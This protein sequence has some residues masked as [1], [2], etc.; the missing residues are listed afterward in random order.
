[1]LPPMPI[2][3]RPAASAGIDRITH[4]HVIKNGHDAI[5]GTVDRCTY[6]STSS[7]PLNAAAACPSI[8]GMSDIKA[9]LRTLSLTMLRALGVLNL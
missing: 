9:S 3:V 8:D 5:F 4:L 6:W 7:Q 2:A 1:M